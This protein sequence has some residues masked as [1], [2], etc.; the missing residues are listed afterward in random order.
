MRTPSPSPPPPSSAA[1]GQSFED[2]VGGRLLAWVG[3]A[4]MVLGIVFLFAMAVSNGWVGE[5]A[6]TA[7]GGAASAALLAVGT[8][9]HPRKGRT[10]AALAAAAAGIAGLFVTFTVAAQV[11]GLMPAPVAIAGTLGVGGIAIALAVVW[12][13]Q[14]IA[15]LGIVGALLAP[16]LAGTSLAGAEVW[17]LWAAFASA[18]GVLVW[19]RWDWLALVAFLVATPQWLVWLS[20]AGDSST[21]LVG[22]TAFGLVGAIAAIGF[23]V[24]A[25]SAGLSQTSAALLALNALVLAA[26]GWFG[27]SM[28]DESLLARGWLAAL[29]LTHLVAGVLGRR[30]PRVSSELTLLSLIVGVVLADLAFEASVG[31]PAVSLGFAASVALFASLRRRLA[32]GSDAFVVEGGI[33]LHLCLALAHALIADAPPAMLTGGEGELA[34]AGLVLA[35]LAAACL[36][37]ARTLQSSAPDWQLMLNGVAVASVAYLAAVTLDGATLVAVWSLEAVVLA[38]IWRRTAEDVAAWGA[39]A[40][41]GLALAHIVTYEVT[42]DALVFGLEHPVA[43]A[44]AGA[45]GTVAAAALAYTGPA[46]DPSRPWLAGAAA[47]TA[48]YV[49]SALVVTPFQPGDAGVVDGEWLA[50]DVRQEGQMLLSALWALIGSGALVIGL[51]RDLRL[52]RIGALALLL[53]SVGKVFVFDLA[54]LDSIYR[55]VSF[56]G[57]GL[58]LL[59]SAFVWQRIRPRPPEDLRE[60]PEGLR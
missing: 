11:Y 13:A 20:G 50:L 10:E 32:A 27:F 1:A 41:L 30:S 44:L 23:E 34:P 31:G 14:L 12:R 54:T 39:L 33:G 19:Q 35:G 9:L 57:L 43:A 18:A 47:V 26:A 45:A 52:L 29:A 8:W 17:V 24:R 58:L 51:R 36:V 25:A 53:T 28:L 56:I 5:G 2:L 46:G 42:P 48:L 22:L 15:A 21:A 55:V 6:R 4:A 16:V 59:A 49:V 37:S 38:A 60:V 7:M 3:G 40:N